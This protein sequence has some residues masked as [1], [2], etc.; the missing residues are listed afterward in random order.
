M[1]ESRP[2]PRMGQIYLD[3]AA[4]ARRRGDRRVSTEHLALALLTNADSVTAQALGVTADTART[5]LQGLDRNALARLGIVASFDEAFTPRRSK[6][7]LRLT[8]A[9]REVFTGLRHEAVGERLSARHVL[10][11]LLRRERPDPAAELF[12]ALQ[13]DRAA[14]R[15]RL[16]QL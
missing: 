3:A 15:E 2:G 12:D 10:L 4:E 8:P 11:A 13:V 7:R 1:G 9:A 6:K 16:R 14:V 5:T